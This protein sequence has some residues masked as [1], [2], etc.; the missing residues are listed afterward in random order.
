MPWATN[1]L[2]L[3][4]ILVASRLI[5]FDQPGQ[6]ALTHR[7]TLMRT[8]V[9]QPKELTTQIEH[10]NRAAAYGHQLP[11]PWRNLGH[12]RNHVFAHPMSSPGDVWR[13]YIPHSGAATP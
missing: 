7:A 8:T 3:A 12:C 6:D 5:R 13:R 1:D 11:A 4:R 10:R 9:E 2:A